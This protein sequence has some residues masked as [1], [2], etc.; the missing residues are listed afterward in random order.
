MSCTAWSPRNKGRDIRLSFT[1]ESSHWARSGVATAAACVERLCR[2]Q[3]C[4]SLKPGV[5]CRVA[6]L[7]SSREA[8]FNVLG[9]QLLYLVHLAAVGVNAHRRGSARGKR[10]LRRHVGLRDL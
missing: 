9:E 1:S 4:Q 6:G 8:A 10:R 7:W 3:L 2:R 5:V